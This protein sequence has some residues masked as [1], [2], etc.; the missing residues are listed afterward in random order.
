MVPVR[1]VSSFGGIL[2]AYLILMPFYSLVMKRQ[3]KLCV[4]GL[5]GIVFSA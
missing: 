5:S 2:D 3:S 4:S 1:S